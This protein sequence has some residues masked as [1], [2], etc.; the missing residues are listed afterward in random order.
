MLFRSRGRIGFWQNVRAG[1][2]RW[3]YEDRISPVSQRELDEG[4]HH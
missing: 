1:F 3:F 4:S 2:S